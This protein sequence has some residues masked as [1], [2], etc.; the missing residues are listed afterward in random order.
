MRRRAFT[1]VELLVVIGIIAILIAILLPTL[2]RARE[3]AN[4]VKCA[5]NMRQIVLGLIMYANDDK[6]GYL[7]YAEDRG[8]PAVPGGSATDSW[9]VLHP[10]KTQVRD[11]NGATVTGLVLGT[12]IYVKN[13]ATFTCPST[14]NV[15]TD[16]NHLR[17]IA[18]GPSDRSG[19]HSYEPRTWAWSGWTFPD[20]FVV[21]P[22]KAPDTNKTQKTIRK[23]KASSEL[24]M[25]D[26]EEA[27]GTIDQNNWP[28]VRDNHGKDGFNMGFLDGHVSFVLEG[29]AILAAYV[30]GHYPPG[31]SANI[32]TRYKL[33]DGPVMRWLP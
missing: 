24:L 6:Q 16:P 32:L 31:V 5:S 8:S 21:P 13:L 3:Q 12:P 29:R 10:A 18:S 9:Y 15:V 26:T 4:R 2:K 27:T 20:G 30:D 14:E 19:R 7:G 17:D 33:Q 11:W 1:L 23:F 25:T 22:A 28:D